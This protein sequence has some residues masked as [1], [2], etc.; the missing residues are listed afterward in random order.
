ME[1]P[2]PVDDSP[3]PFTSKRDDT[4]D[5]SATEI[6]E[7]YMSKIYYSDKY[8]D[9]NF[10]Y[11]HVILPK[12]IF[13]LIK[14]AGAADRLL[15]ENEW[16]GLGVQGSLGWVHYS[17]HKPEPHILLFRRSLEVARQQ[18]RGTM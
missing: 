4:K 16:R 6:I 14:S 17:L 11:R 9:D 18:E 5:L 12:E 7:K 13:A 10:Q 3:D 15:K 2:I 1:D 8:E